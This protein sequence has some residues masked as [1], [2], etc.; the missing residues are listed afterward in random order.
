MSKRCC[1]AC[2]ELIQLLQEKSGTKFYNVYGHHSTVFPVQ[3]P[4]GVPIDVL[5]KMIEIFE[6]YL[7]RELSVLQ[8]KRLRARD[9]DLLFRSPSRQSVGS[10]ISGESATTGIM[11]LTKVFPMAKV[12]EMEKLGNLKRV[13]GRVN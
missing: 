11:A 1:P 2:W 12:G 6:S 10:N 9:D 8:E 5:A 7:D 13:G 3:L 4:S